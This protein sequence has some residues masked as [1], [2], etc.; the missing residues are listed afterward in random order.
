MKQFLNVLKKIMLNWGLFLLIGT[1]TYRTIFKNM[2]FHKTL[3][4]IAESNYRFLFIGIAMIFVVLC[5][6]AICVKRN[7]KMMGEEEGFFNCLIYTFTGNFFSGITPAASGG[8]PMEIILMHKKGVSAIHGTLALIMDLVTYQLSTIT[9]AILS[10]LLAKTRVDALLGKYIWFL[11]LGIILN[12]ILLFGLLFAMFS[13]RFIYRIL[14]LTAKIIRIFSNDK[15]NE[16]IHKTADIIR[17][18]HLSANLLIDNKLK[19]MQNFM[20]TF[21]R[22]ICLHSI[23]YWVYKALG[24]NGFGFIEIMGLQSMLYI[25]CAVLPFPGGIG[26]AEQ[27]FAKFFK[28]IFP[29]KLLP[30]SMILSRGIGSYFTIVISGSVFMAFMLVNMLSTHKLK[31]A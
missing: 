25:S 18:Y 20:L 30:I 16:F 4:L 12:L 7:L 23:P 2:D 15:A 8:Q 17:Q 27:N 28:Y 29:E 11:Y 10:Y 19:F 14:N 5:L 3:V 1:F 31:K 9:I 21:I 13:K 6:E 22:I 26:I 24:L